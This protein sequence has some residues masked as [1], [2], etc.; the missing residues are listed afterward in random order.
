MIASIGRLCRVGYSLKCVLM[1]RFGK[2]TSPLMLSMRQPLEGKATLW[3]CLNRCSILVCYSMKTA[4]LR[5]LM[6]HSH[7]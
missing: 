6:S 2:S 5:A 3:Q 4:D 1:L 7:I